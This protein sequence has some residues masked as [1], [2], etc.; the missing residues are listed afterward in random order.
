M[1]TELK[2][3][4]VKQRMTQAQFAEKIGVGR[5]LYAAVEKGTRDGALAFWEQ[6]KNVFDIPESEIWRYTQNDED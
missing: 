1:R 4:R 6:F 2:V 3:F 5:A